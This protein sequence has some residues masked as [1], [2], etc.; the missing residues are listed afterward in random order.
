M[1]PVYNKAVDDLY[2]QFE[3]EVRS[4]EGVHQYK[5]KQLSGDVAANRVRS[6]SSA[7]TSVVRLGGNVA[8]QGALNPT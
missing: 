4:F 2:C 5:K 6:S 7:R 3:S 8:N 1:A